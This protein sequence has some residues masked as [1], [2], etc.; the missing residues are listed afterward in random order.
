MRGVFAQ[1]SAWLSVLT[2]LCLRCITNLL[3]CCRIGWRESECNSLHCMTSF[4]FNPLDADG[5]NVHDKYLR[6]RWKR[7]RNSN[8]CLYFLLHFL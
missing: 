1:C 8:S 3:Q 6:K 2:V 5:L 4:D 7:D